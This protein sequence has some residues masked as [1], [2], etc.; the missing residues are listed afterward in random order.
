VRLRA[1]PYLPGGLRPG[2]LAPG[3]S[4]RSLGRATALASILAKLGDERRVVLRRGTVRSAADAMHFA[5]GREAE[6]HKA[7]RAAPLFAGRQCS[8]PARDMAFE[9]RRHGLAAYLPEREVVSPPGRVAGVRR[10]P[11]SAIRVE[12]RQRNYRVVSELQA[13]L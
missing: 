5:R 1:R 7:I 4:V 2:P 10:A 8:L 13:G 9:D 3:R 11:R 6:V 12:P